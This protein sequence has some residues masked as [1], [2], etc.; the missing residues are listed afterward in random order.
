MIDTKGA[1]YEWDLFAK[2]SRL[3]SPNQACRSGPFYKNPPFPFRVSPKNSPSTLAIALP[4][5]SRTFTDADV[6]RAFA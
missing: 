6:I 5:T 1:S 3:T 2:F 4:T